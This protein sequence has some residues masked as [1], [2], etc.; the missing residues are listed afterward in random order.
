[1]QYNV[2]KTCQAKDGRA[3]NLINGECENCYKT[4]ELGVVHNFTY[5]KRTDEEIKRTMAILDSTQLE[6]E[7]LIAQIPKNPIEVPPR[8]KVSKDIIKMAAI[9][10]LGES[11]VDTYGDKYDVEDIVDCYIDGMDGYEIVKKLDDHYGWEGDSQLVEELDQ[12][13]WMVRDMVDNE[14]KHWVKTYDIKPDLE[15]GTVITKGTI[16]GVSEYGRGQYRVKEKGCE[17]AN[18]YL[19]VNFEDAV[20]L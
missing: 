9:R 10:I 16:T 12:M 19:L 15:V 6:M 4:R 2:C 7:S 11:P 13:G 18:R 1:M 5:L 14:I 3:G 8:P 20:K 17:K